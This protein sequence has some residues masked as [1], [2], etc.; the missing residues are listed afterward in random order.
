M[1][2]NLSSKKAKEN[3]PAGPATD[4][5]PKKSRNKSDSIP[6]ESLSSQDSRKK[7]SSQTEK[8]KQRHQQAAPDSKEKAPI[9]PIEFG[10]ALLESIKGKADEKLVES[11]S[12][13]LDTLRQFSAV[14]SLI[15][16]A[17]AYELTKG[18]IIETGAGH[19]DFE[20]KGKLAQYERVGKELGIPSRTIED[21][22]RIYH[23]CIA[24]PVAQ[25]ADE[26]QKAAREEV[27]L[28]KAIRLPRSFLL[29][30]AAVFDSDIALEIAEEKINGFGKK[31]YT[32]AKFAADIE[33]F[34][35]RNKNEQ[36]NKPGA[37]DDQEGLL[38]GSSADEPK[39]V[40]RS[41]KLSERAE[42]CLGEISRE[43][44]FSLDEAISL[45]IIYCR[46]HLEDFA[47]SP[48]VSAI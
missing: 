18:I 37:D 33:H 24:E 21:N 11:V 17:C 8:G 40:Q 32:L 5:F 39:H 9:P 30:A 46:E 34:K 45:A 1:L 42:I 26:S 2:K 31:N 29:K 48:E 13:A 19:R 44:N 35:R 23:Y 7:H 43:I 47:A 28:E 4:G 12:R 14:T 20:K 15:S 6:D 10:L 16:G 38:P 3:P 41:V 22:S 25:I 36:K 27:L